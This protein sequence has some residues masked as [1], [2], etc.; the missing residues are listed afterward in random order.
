ML[1]LLF[2]LIPI[3]L[4]VAFISI[5]SII[6][7]MKIEPIYEMPASQSEGTFV[8]KNEDVY[9]IWLSGKKYK[10]TPLGQIGLRLENMYTRQ[11]V[12]LSR[13][14]MRTSVSGFNT[15]RVSIYSFRAE[16]GTY[17]L[18]MTDEADFMD[19]LGA[20]FIN[21]ISRSPVDYSQFSFQVR[22]HVS[23]FPLV[24]CIFGIVLGIHAILVGL[25]LPMVL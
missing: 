9:E 20:K 13:S 10:K 11:D 1:D 15:A 8:I 25:I 14:I 5:K 21:S 6:N 4:V 19:R 22:K 23:L 17:I 18:S 3:G 12:E 7:F 2:I 16:A 24:L